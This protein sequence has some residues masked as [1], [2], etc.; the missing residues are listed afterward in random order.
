MKSFIHGVFLFLLVNQVSAQVA[1][2]SLAPPQLYTPM[3]SSSLGWLAGHV[4]PQL[5]WLET[6]SATHY[7][8]QMA[9]DSTD[10]QELVIDRRIEDDSNDD[11]CNWNEAYTCIDINGHVGFFQ[12]R[13]RALSESD[14]SA[15]SE[16]WHVQVVALVSNEN[17]TELTAGLSIDALYPNPVRS[18]LITTLS[19]HFGEKG[20][21]IIYDMLGREVDRVYEGMIGPEKMQF[22]TDVSE[23]PGGVYIYTVKTNTQQVSQRIQ[24]IP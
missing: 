19:N 4:V 7:H 5:L 15:W 24:I 8:V 21:I 13:V 1:S 14:S 11:P 9:V 16:T 18:Q 17:T 22:M 3:D 12:W 23:L 6:D 2:D 10:F 20:R